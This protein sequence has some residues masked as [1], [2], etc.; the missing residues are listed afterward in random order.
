MKSMLESGGRRSR[1]RIAISGTIVLDSCLR[2]E[3]FDLENVC[4][5]RSC[6]SNGVIMCTMC[7]AV[8]YCGGRV[9]RSEL[10]L[11]SICACD[12]VSYHLSVVAQGLEGS[13][14]CLWLDAYHS[15]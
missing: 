5:R 14:I 4:T 1:H 11:V 9:R 12:V 6:G 3:C 8:R 7:N 10:V 2:P 15:S 13:S